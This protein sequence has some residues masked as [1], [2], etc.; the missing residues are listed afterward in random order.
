M[1][2]WNEDITDF[3]HCFMRLYNEVKFEVLQ[4]EVNGVCEDHSV[5]CGEFDDFRASLKKPP[6]TKTSNS[7]AELLDMEATFD[8]EVTPPAKQPGP[9][10]IPQ[11]FYGDVRG[12]RCSSSRACGTGSERLEPF[13]TKD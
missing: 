9:T 4:E 2:F 3:K 11:N 10:L 6:S 12:L 13:G 5:L 7:E 8:A 1:W